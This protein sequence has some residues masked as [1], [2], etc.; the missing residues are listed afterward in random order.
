M[1]VTGAGQGI[2]RAIAI[3]AAAEGTSVVVADY[4]GSDTGSSDPATEVVAE[5]VAAG[6]Q[7]VAV[8]AD[9]STMPGGAHRWAW[10]H[11]SVRH[12][13]TARPY[14]AHHMPAQPRRDRQKRGDE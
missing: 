13:W 6:G 8:A 12:M 9:V 4:D 14:E 3:A 10:H 1:V 2:G 11:A 7:A 5:I